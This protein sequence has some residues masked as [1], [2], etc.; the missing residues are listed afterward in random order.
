[1]R[2]EELRNSLMILTQKYVADSGKRSCFL[3]Q[4]EK[5]PCP[6]AKAVLA[7]IALSGTS[8][9]NEDAALIKEIAFHFV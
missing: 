7:E 6:P 1:M 3:N 8:V 5:S 4:I 9:S 2:L